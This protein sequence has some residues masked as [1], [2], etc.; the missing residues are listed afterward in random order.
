MNKF[1]ID[2]SDLKDE[3]LLECIIQ[4]SKVAV[5]DK[6]IKFYTLETSGHAEPRDW[7]KEFIKHIREAEKRIYKNR[8][9]YI[10]RGGGSSKDCVAFVFYNDY[11]Y[12]FDNYFCDCP[13][14]EEIIKKSYMR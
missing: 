13:I 4:K 12:S 1:S 8:C 11:V 9:F 14:F 5:K 2:T 6:P 10:V 7:E 3:I